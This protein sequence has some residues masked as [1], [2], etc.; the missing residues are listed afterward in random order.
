VSLVPARAGLYGRTIRH[1]RPAQLVH[2]VRLRAQQEALR[3]RPDPFAAR[4]ALEPATPAAWPDGFRAVDD[5]APPDC[6]AFDALEAGT[7]TFLHEPRALGSPVGWD[8]P[9]A[10]QLWLYHLHSWEWA[11]T[12]AAHAD[13]ERARQVFADQ[14]RSWRAAT[15]FGRWNAWA[16]YPTSLRAWVLVNVFDR[17]VAGSAV[18][19]DVVEHLALHA[20][21]VAH[22]LE[23]D[24]GGNHLVKNLKA[25][26]GLG[27]FF[28]HD[29]LLA[30]AD[31]HLR[32]EVGVQ[33]LA[34]GGH[35][36]LSPSYHA[37]VLADLIDVARLQRAA[38]HTVTAGLDAAIAAM[39]RWLGAMLMPDGDVP[40]L[41]DCE[42]V[43]RARLAALAPTAAPAE[44]LTVLGPS[45]YVVARVGRFHLVADVGQPCP[46]DLPAHAQADCLTFEL[47]VDG[48][49]V[50]VD[51]GTSV[52][53][54]GPQRQAERG[55]AL[56]NTVTVDGVDQ[57]EVW[58]G[59][60]AGRRARALLEGSAV[61]DGV[62]E[63]TGSH[64]GY[65][66]L[67]GSPRHRRRWR[68][69]PDGLELTDHIDGT[70]HHHLRFHLLTTVEPDAGGARG[71]ARGPVPSVLVDGPHFAPPPRPVP[72]TS[73]EAATHAVGFGTA[74]T[75]CSVVALASVELPI[76]LTTR[77]GPAPAPPD[78]GPPLSTDR[79]MPIE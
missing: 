66:H 20:G 72:L 31:H 11:W 40:L 50:V 16:P 63:V 7:F 10:T 24:V 34:D 21:F 4:W 77:I 67:P 17:L 27:T 19:D 14:W 28:G 8:P 42:P 79:S 12:L 5:L 76:E 74:E 53:G 29:D 68:L 45:G 59:F 56:H 78:P 6:G 13:R 39:R 15:R 47:A 69:G 51:P 43:G 9:D 3:R 23:L 71:P 35:Y 62:V 44:P 75:A 73:V 30:R 22:N 58:G 38:G 60:R 37:Q 48:R 61:V 52:Y 1:L 55:T 25:L 18:E 46:P 65:R 32:R 33:V 57:T 70:G 49:R 2:R 64:D 54:S 26:V 36:E 41:N